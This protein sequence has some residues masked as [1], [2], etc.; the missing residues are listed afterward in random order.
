MQAYKEMKLQY[1]LALN[2]FKRKDIHVF[3]KLFN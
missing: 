2:I 3:K 1:P